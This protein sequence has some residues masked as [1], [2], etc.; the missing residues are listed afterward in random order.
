MISI[1]NI[2]SSHIFDKDNT[3]S[4]TFSSS[5]FDNTSVLPL[6][7]S[8]F[9]IP[10]FYCSLELFTLFW[11]YF[12][13]IKLDNARCGGVLSGVLLDKVVDSHFPF[14]MGDCI[15]LFVLMDISK[16]YGKNCVHDLVI[17]FVLVDM[18]LTLLSFSSLF[19]VWVVY[20]CM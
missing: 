2:E 12:S 7:P 3:F 13:T 16:L 4:S 8:L 10:F 18:T 15:L 20:L 14:M 17:Y 5:A 19:Y 6:C 11:G 1:C 9:E